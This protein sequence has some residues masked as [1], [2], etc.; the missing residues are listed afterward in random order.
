MDVDVEVKSNKRQDRDT[1]NSDN[2]EAD[3]KRQK[4][5]T[6]DINSLDVKKIV[7]SRTPKPYKTKPIMIYD[8]S[9]VDGKC[10]LGTIHK[11]VGGIIPQREIS[12]PTG[13]IINTTTEN[14]CKLA[15]EISAWVDKYHLTAKAFISQGQPHLVLAFGF[16]PVGDTLYKPLWEKEQQ[17]PKFNVE[18]CVICLD[19]KSTC[20]IIPC[21]HVC[22]CEPCVIECQKENMV[23]CPK[24][25]SNVTEA[26]KVYF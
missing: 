1:Q 12:F 25:R 17:T 15:E 24:C 18:N 4:V 26:R 2:V 10:Q 6:K 14:N 7:F 22:L 5:E 20:V 8:I 19:K 13:I 21:M 11:T 23:H 16:G 9:L 3:P